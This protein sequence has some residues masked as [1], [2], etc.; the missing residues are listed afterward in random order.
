MK[1]TLWDKILNF[2][3]LLVISPIVLGMISYLVMFDYSLFFI[4]LTS[5]LFWTGIVFG[6]I[7]AKRKGYT[8]WACFAILFA[9]LGGILG[10]VFGIVA[11]F[12]IKKNPKL[13]GK[14]LAITAIIIAIPI[15]FFYTFFQALDPVKFLPPESQL[16]MY[17]EEACWDE[18]NYNTTY[19]EINPD[20]SS[21]YICSCLDKD[22]Y[23]LSQYSIPA[24]FI[25]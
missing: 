20:N 21:E 14:G 4:L 7:K 6:F 11:L 15:I 19:V 12:K 3:W 18:P 24:D 25:S 2:W 16:H 13:K 9:L 22:D 10:I 1:N 23:I 5:S 17:C 8:L